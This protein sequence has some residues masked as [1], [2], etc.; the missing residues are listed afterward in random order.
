[1]RT[2]LITASDEAYAPLLRGLVE[3]LQQISP[4]P[5]SALACFDLGL[6]ASSRVWLEQYAVHVATPGWDLPVAESL[7]ETQPDL[8]ALTVRPFLPEYFPGYDIYLW[9]DSDAWV[10]QRFAVDWYI[11]GASRGALA[12]TPQVHHAYRQ[13][14]SGLNWRMQRMH[15]YFGKDAAQRVLSETYINAGVFALPAEAAHWAEWAKSFRTGLKESNGLVCCDQT[16]LNYAVWT[17]QLPFQPLP[18]LCNWLCHLAFP[19]FDEKRQLLCEPAIPR[20]PIGIVHLSA[21]TKD[22]TIE[23]GENGDG[24]TMSLRFPGKTPTD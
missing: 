24:G 8:R 16:A 9:I 11:E 3:S 6:G 17:H 23:R 14:L 19:Y 4:R 7:K 15:A 2:L 21:N 18:A 10:Q 1:M 22:I 13:A 20:Q 5:Y 12:A